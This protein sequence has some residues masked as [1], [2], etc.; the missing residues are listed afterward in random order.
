[1]SVFGAQQM[2]FFHSKAASFVTFERLGLLTL[3]YC[4]EVFRLQN[5]SPQLSDLLVDSAHQSKQASRTREV[6]DM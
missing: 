1:M 2:P 4:F 3:V 5:T 6:F